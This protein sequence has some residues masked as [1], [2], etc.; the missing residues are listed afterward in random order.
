VDRD[1]VPRFITHNYIDLG[2]IREISRFRSGEG[3][4]YADSRETCRSM[5]HYFKT[6]TGPVARTIPIYSPVS[7]VVVR[8]ITEWAG[9]QIHI[10]PDD[11]PA[12]VVILFH[13]NATASIADGTRFAGGQQIGTHVGDETM[14]DVAVS[15]N[16]VSGYRLVSWFD[17]ITD[18]VFEFY[19]ARGLQARS[20][21]IITRAERDQQPLTCSG[22]AFANKGT[23]PNWIQLR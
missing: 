16:D 4:S 11:Y 23:L 22:E 13:V 19:R 15:V 21:A 9:V 12:F 20:D 3:H 14:S 17:A 18:P 8:T 1:G 6:P 5:K 2:Y 10:A 7:G